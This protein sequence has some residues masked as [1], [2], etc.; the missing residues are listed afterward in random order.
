M[1][2]GR[3]RLR[4]SQNQ[5]RENRPAVGACYSRQQLMGIASFHPSY[6][7]RNIQEILLEKTLVNLANGRLKRAP[8]YY[9][10][11]RPPY[12]ANKRILATTYAV[13]AIR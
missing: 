10:I 5:K 2:Q 7:L 13:P 1:G 4:D 12:L 8:D 6:A 9:P 3:Q 11:D